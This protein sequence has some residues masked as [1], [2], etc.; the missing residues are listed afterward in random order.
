[1]GGGKAN[2]G[3]MPVYFFSHGNNAG[4]WA[5][6]TWRK[7]VKFN[8]IDDPALYKCISIEESFERDRSDVQYYI[9]RNK[10]INKDTVEKSRGIAITNTDEDRFKRGKH[11]FVRLFQFIYSQT[12]KEELGKPL[13]VFIKENRIV[14]DFCE[15]VQT[16]K[17]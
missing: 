16:D 15:K 3:E 11:T 10:W 14:V 5:G 6:E 8:S 7:L 4:P 13:D 12:F 2:M 9:Q 1:M 17:E